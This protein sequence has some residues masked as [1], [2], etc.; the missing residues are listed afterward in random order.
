[1]TL[2]R[3]EQPQVP[4]VERRVHMFYKAGDGESTCSLPD[5]YALP[6]YTLMRS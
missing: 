2:G 4:P 6:I 1:M 3:S 5:I